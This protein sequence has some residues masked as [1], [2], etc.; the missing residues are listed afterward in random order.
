MED[1]FRG[2]H[3][4]Y[5]LIRHPQLSDGKM[6]ATVVDLDEPE[7]EKKNAE[8]IGLPGRWYLVNK[9]NRAMPVTMVIEE[10]DK[11]YYKA[12]HV[13]AAAAMPGGGVEGETISAEVIAYGIGKVMP[14]GNEDLLWHFYPSEVTCMGKDVN[15]IGSEVLKMTS[16]Y[17]LVKK[18]AQEIAAAKAAALDSTEPTRPPSGETTQE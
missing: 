3:P 17:Q 2:D 16:A 8:I 7:W 5:L 9:A 18:R 11:P 1:G 14:D 15:I 13:G 10:G 6:V 12:R 4:F